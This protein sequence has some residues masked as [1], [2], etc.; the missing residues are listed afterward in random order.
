MKKDNKK[1]KNDKPLQQNANIPR[2]PQHEIYLLYNRS[3]GTVD[4]VI[5]EQ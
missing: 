5:S 1:E 3:L 2:T 4:I